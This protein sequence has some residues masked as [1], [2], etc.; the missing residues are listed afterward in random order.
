[1]ISARYCTDI[2]MEGITVQVDMSSLKS[3]ESVM[4]TYW[5]K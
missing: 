4:K 1:M 5:I 2:M 3:R